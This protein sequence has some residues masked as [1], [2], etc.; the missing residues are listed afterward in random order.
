MGQ[1]QKYSGKN[2][3]QFKK[4]QLQIYNVRNDL[5]NILLKRLES[6]DATTIFNTM[7]IMGKLKE[8]FP[9]IKQF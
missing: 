6:D 8:I 1:V 3:F 4:Y 5:C 7:I 2:R 9:S